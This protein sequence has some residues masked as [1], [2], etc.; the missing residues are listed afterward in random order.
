MEKYTMRDKLIRSK[1]ASNGHIGPYGGKDADYTYT[2]IPECVRSAG[3]CSPG[4]RK[5]LLATCLRWDQETCK[6]AVQNK[7]YHHTGLC[8][9]QYDYPL[10]S[11][12]SREQALLKTIGTA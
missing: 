3:L 11:G 1:Y 5:E 12:V 10:Y 8:T 9:S 2:T 6:T 4:T 7:S